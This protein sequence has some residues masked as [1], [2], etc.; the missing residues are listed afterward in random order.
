MEEVLSRYGAK[1]INFWDDCFTLNTER[2]YEIC[3]LIKER[4]IYVP[5]EFNARVDNVDLPLLKEMKK[6]G[7]YLVGFGIES[8]TDRIL[9]NIMKDATTEQVR[10]AFKL[11]REAGMLT[12]GFF[13]LGFVGET[14][15]DMLRTIEFAKE[16]KVDYAT[17]TLLIPLPGT[18]DYERAQK[19]GS[20]DKYYYKKEILSDIDLPKHPIY[21]PKNMTEEKLMKLHRFAYKSFYFR[22]PYMLAQIKNVRSM[23]DIKKMINGGLTVIKLK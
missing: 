22:L 11:C 14:E 10:R 6:C 16:I 12:R 20:F 7:F 18:K 2:V 19:E 5:I 1:E 15:E 21:I 8:G 17:F 4:G 3:R 23:A 9:K 13:I